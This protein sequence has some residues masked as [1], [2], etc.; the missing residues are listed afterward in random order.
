MLE[1]PD[2]PP[3]Q[4]IVQTYWY[5]LQGTYCAYCKLFYVSKKTKWLDGYEVVTH[6][7]GHIDGVEGD[8]ADEESALGGI[9]EA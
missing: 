3:G 4:M 7:V 1:E 9:V 8:A 6:R 2:E 5:K